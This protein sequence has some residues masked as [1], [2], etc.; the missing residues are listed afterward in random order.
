[1]FHFN[2]YMLNTCN[3]F[4]GARKMDVGQWKWNSHPSSFYTISSLQWR[5]SQFFKDSHAIPIGTGRKSNA[6]S[7]EMALDSRTRFSSIHQNSNNFRIS[8]DFQFLS[9]KIVLIFSNNIALDFVQVLGRDNLQWYF[10]YFK[11]VLV[12]TVG[13]QGAGQS[14]LQPVGSNYWWVAGSA[15]GSPAQ[16]KFP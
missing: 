13:P 7:D 11:L 12:T 1:M 15:I 3:S 14:A 4:F 9:L 5:L 16:Y 8:L 10:N 2:H 6:I